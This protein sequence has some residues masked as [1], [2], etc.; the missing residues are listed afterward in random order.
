MAETLKWLCRLPF[1]DTD[2][3][4]SL[5]GMPAR[6]TVFNRL[7]VLRRRGLVMGFNHSVGER[8]RTRRQLVSAD[9]IGAYAAHLGIRSSDLVKQHPISREWLGLIADRIDNVAQVYRLASL[10]ADT[11]DAGPVAVNLRRNDNF[12]AYI[13]PWPG[14]AIGVIIQGRGLLPASVNKRIRKLFSIMTAILRRRF[15]SYI[16]GRWT[17]SGYVAPTRSGQATP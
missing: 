7:A 14:R 11:M 12:D 5:S 1:A 16:P 4:I 6:A 2:E 15:W 17:V 9:G 8:A 3:L 10:I 13:A